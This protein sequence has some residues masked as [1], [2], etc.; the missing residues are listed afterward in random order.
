MMKPLRHSLV[1]SICDYHE[2]NNKI[3]VSE[4]K[5]RK[6]YGKIDKMHC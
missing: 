6:D 4:V 5:P 1:Y 2:Q 3:A